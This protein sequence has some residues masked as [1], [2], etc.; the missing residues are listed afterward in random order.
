MVNNEHGNMP[1]SAERVLSLIELLLQNGYCVTENFHTLVVL[2]E[3]LVKPNP[4]IYRILRLQRTPIPI[5]LRVK[6][7]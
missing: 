5:G 7:L 3:F 2:A 6:K 1:I 4:D